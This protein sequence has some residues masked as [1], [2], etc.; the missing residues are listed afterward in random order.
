MSKLFI[1]QPFAEDFVVRDDFCDDGPEPGRMVRL[2]EMREFMDN[3]ISYYLPVLLEK[4]VAELELAPLGKALAP[5]GLIVAKRDLLRHGNA[6][7]LKPGIHLVAKIYNEALDA[8][9]SP[10]LVC[11]VSGPVIGDVC[12]FKSDNTV[13]SAAGT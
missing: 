8:A 12:Y 6:P 9:P 13:F 3:D 11:H 5:E 10:F 1:I 4:P 2:Y 7:S